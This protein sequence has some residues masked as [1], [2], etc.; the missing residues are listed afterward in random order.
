MKT[1]SKGRILGVTTE[2]DDQ[3]LDSLKKTPEILQKATADGAS[4]WHYGILPGHFEKQASFKY[5]YA[6]RSKNYLKKPGKGTKPD[7]VFSGAMRREL[8]ANRAIT[9]TGT[10]AKLRMWARAFNLA[11]AMP[12]NSQDA[13]V[14]QYARKGRLRAYPNLKREVKAI[15]DQEREAVSQVVADSAAHQIKPTP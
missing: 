9:T 10:G 4:Y 7:L 11:P 2:I 6:Q 5:G 14:K 15:T 8:I 1:I 13:Y 12:E 3:L